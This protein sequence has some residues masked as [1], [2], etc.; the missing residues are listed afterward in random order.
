MVIRE[1][2]NPET[3]ARLDL[4]V[5]DG[6]E[7]DAA[8]RLRW[9]AERRAYLSRLLAEEALSPEARAIYLRELASL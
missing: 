3:G 6:A 9:S 1:L 4:W 5:C 7:P 2:Y 8:S